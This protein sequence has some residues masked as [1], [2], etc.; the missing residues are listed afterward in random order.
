MAGAGGVPVD[1]P[2]FPSGAPALLSQT[3]TQLRA[4][5]IT[6]IFAVP[7]AAAN[8]RFSVAKIF[9]PQLENPEGPR[10]RRF[11]ARAIS[12]SLGIV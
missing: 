9:V 10:R 5:G 4:A 8:A 1:A 11:G 12:R 6:N 7:L 2:A 3:L